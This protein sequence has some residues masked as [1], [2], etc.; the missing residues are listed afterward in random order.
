MV[1]RALTIVATLCV[2]VAVWV[3]AG[4]ARAGALYWIQENCGSCSPVTRAGVDSV[5]PI[6]PNP[7]IFTVTSPLGA[8]SVESTDA[9]AETWKL[10]AIAGAGVIIPSAEAGSEAAGPVTIAAAQIVEVPLTPTAL[11]PIGT[12]ITLSLNYLVSGSLHTDAIPSVPCCGGLSS[13]QMIASVHS[14]LRPNVAPADFLGD[15]QRF[16]FAADFDTD[17]DVHAFGDGTESSSGAFAGLGANSTFIVR[18]TTAPVNAHV[19]DVLTVGL[20]MFVAASESISLPG[21]F[22][23]SADLS[24]TLTLPSDG[25][26]VFNL[27]D[28]YTINTPDGLIVNDHF[29]PAPEPGVF[30]LLGASLVSIALARLR[31]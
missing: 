12:P 1:R 2:L 16:G 25:Q 23:T 11:F 26:A 4:R 8:T 17:G 3:P 15:L 13:S 24:H 7:Q 10:G 29:V 18:V 22:E 5:A 14:M 9:G 31:K 19:G 20:G 30:A 6:F 27:P 28:G 21:S